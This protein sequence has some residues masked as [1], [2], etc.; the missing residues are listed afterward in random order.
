MLYS[1][2]SGSEFGIELLVVSCAMNEAVTKHLEV[3]VKACETGGLVQG[4]ANLIDFLKQT[5]LAAEV[6][7]PCAYIGVHEENRDG[8]GVSSSHVH[9]LIEDIPS[10]GYHE[11][12][13]KPIAIEVPIGPQGDRTRDFNVRLANESGGKLAPVEP[14]KVRYASVMGSH[15]NQCFRCF[16]ASVEHSSESLTINGKLSIAMLEA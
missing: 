13:N 15:C 4:M 6:R 1:C 11:S 5:G 8:E 3:L 9:Q 14:I 2:S 16:E 10:L 7:M 12:A